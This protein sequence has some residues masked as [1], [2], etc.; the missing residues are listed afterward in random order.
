MKLLYVH[1]RFGSLAGAEANAHIT[2][3]ELGKRGH[4]IGILHGPSTGKG[5][6]A[7]QATFPF[8][9]PLRP[10][11]NSATV[12]KALQDF[13]PDAVYVHKMADLSVIKALVDSRRPLLRMVH[14]HDIYCMRSYKY[15]Y[16]TRAICTRAAS[17][18]C[19]FPCLAS[20]VKRSGP[21]FPLKWVS[22]SEKKRE[23]ALNRRFDRMVVVTTYMRD[24]LLHNGFDPGRIEIHAPVPR[25]GD[26][27]LR[28]N[29]GDRNLIIYAGQIIRGKGV[30][31]LLEA[32]ARVK[33]RF[34]C[35][36]LGDGNHKA[37]CEKLAVK[38]GLA[39]RVTFKGFIPQEELKNYYREC[40]VVALSSVW[41][42]PIATIGLEVMR[43]ALP[44]VAFDAG[45]IKDW[46]LDGHNGY[47]VRWMDRD[48]Y[49]ARLDELLLNKNL[50]R[51]MGE[52]GLKLVSD[53]YDFDGYIGDLEKMF[54][55]VIALKKM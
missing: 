44:V 32:L 47:L 27:S 15:N 17:P 52:A 45:G 38:L 12:Q 41:P 22:Y 21:G 33:T 9:A 50:A 4:S 55:S 19:V 5:E 6:P 37:F 30:D 23:I 13:D 25:M 26:P 11:D 16:F 20:V 36:I 7:W 1:E 29:F 39:D 24:E 34:E 48:A 2:A 10:E 40:S 51:Q 8:R 53:R 14:D 43:Y 49:A 18:Y 35:V 31:V 42:E 54:A 46:L 3:T 28:S